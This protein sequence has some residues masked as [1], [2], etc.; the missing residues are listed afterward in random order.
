MVLLLA[1]GYA[2]LSSRYQQPAG[3]ISITAEMGNAGS[4]LVPGSDVKYL[5]VRVGRVADLDYTGGKATAKIQ[6]FPQEVCLPAPTGLVLVVTAKTLLGEKQVELAAAEGHTAGEEPCLAAGDHVVAAAEPTELQAVI[7]ELNRVFSAIDPDDLAAIFEAFAQQRGEEAVLQENIRLG[8]ELS[9]FGARTAQQN[10]D[11]LRRLA[12][13]AEALEPRAGD[14]TRLNAN[15]AEATAVLREREGDLSD[16]LDVT[17][18][19]AT[20]LAEFLETSEALI[21]GLMQSGDIVGA[22]L[23]DNQDNV[24]S[25]IEGLIVY[26]QGLGRGGMLL[27]D[28]SEWAPFKVFLSFDFEGL[29]NGLAP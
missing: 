21:D 14:L 1:V 29:L 22:V 2:W 10:I 17:L 19:F 28:G 13:I 23:E 7:D 25:L 26:G 3:T 5:G 9:E 16:T 11:N 18:D 20:G 4:G 15:L 24:G 12:G 6:I 8:N 27:D